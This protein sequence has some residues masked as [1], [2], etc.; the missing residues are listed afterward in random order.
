MTTD[1]ND[2]DYYKTVPKD[3]LDLEDVSDDNGYCCCTIQIVNDDDEDDDEEVFVDYH[4]GDPVLLEKKRHDYSYQSNR[5]LKSLL[6]AKTRVVYSTTRDVCPRIPLMMSW[7]LGFLGQ[8]ACAFGVLVMSSVR[9]EGNTSDSSSILD[10]ITMDRIMINFMALWNGDRYLM[11]TDVNTA[12]DTINTT[13]IT[14]E[15]WDIIVECFSKAMYSINTFFTIFFM[16][17]VVTCMIPKKHQKCGQSA[18]SSNHQHASTTWLQV[19]LVIMTLMTSVSF[20]VG[21]GMFAITWS[22]LPHVLSLMQLPLFGL[23][24]LSYLSLI[25]LL[26]LF[27]ILM[28]AI[29]VAE[30]D[31]QEDY[32]YD[33]DEQ[34]LI[35]KNKKEATKDSKKDDDDE[36]M[37]LVIHA[38]YALLL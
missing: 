38:E 4:N 5:V 7:V 34:Q 22:L 19:L 14:R 33:Y 6:D 11:W 15:E 12:T 24:Q 32:D 17:G 1:M 35:K 21:M 31:V 8:L 25:F 29:Q 2:I 26:R 23:L 20:G 30:D 27:D 9:M 10:S 3:D 13:P 37:S 18:S 16:L 28:T 36:E